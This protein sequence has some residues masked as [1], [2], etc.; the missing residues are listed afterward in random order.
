MTLLIAE[1][2]RDRGASGGVAGQNERVPAAESHGPRE[3]GGRQGNLKAVRSGQ[4]QHVPT[5]RGSAGRLHA[6]VWQEI[7]RGQHLW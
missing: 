1:N 6:D 4:E 7:G 3:D 5:A 2:G